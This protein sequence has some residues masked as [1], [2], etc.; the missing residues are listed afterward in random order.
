F[1]QP[2]SRRVTTPSRR[3]TTRRNA[4][5]ARNTTPPSSAWPA[6]DSTSCSPW[7]ETAASTNQ[8]LKKLRRRLDFKHR[9]PPNFNKVLNAVNVAH[10]PVPSAPTHTVASFDHGNRLSGLFQRVRRHQP[11][12]ASTNDDDITVKRWTSI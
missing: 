7:S 10:L 11:S 2:G 3:P 12:R 1:A 4:P 5:K 9:D 6:E 8:H